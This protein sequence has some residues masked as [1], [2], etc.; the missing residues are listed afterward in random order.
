MT[1]FT[2]TVTS[3]QNAQEWGRLEVVVRDGP[4]AGQRRI[5]RSRLVV[6]TSEKSDLQ[7]KDRTVS[8]RHLSLEPSPNGVRIVD[9][10][11]RNGSWLD[12]CRI[13]DAELAPG[14]EIRIGATVLGLEV[15]D[16]STPDETDTPSEL[17]VSFGRF[18]GASSSLQLLYRQLHKAAATNATILL[19]GESGAGKE[20]LAE[21]VHEV[22]PRR[23]GPFIVLD[24]SSLPEKLIE[25]A[26]FGHEKGAF[27][28]AAQRRRGAF[29]EADKGT[30][31]LDEVGE[32]PLD[33]QTRLLRTLDRRQ[34]QRVGSSTVIPVDVRVVAATN[35]NLELEVEEGRFRL[36]VFHRL[37]VVMLRVPPL[38]ERRADIEPL[39]KHFV[40]SFGGDPALLT[41]T[42]LERL[43]THAWPGNVRELRNFVERLSVLGD[44]VGQFS[45]RASP[46]GE[47]DLEVIA[48]SGQAY[49]PAKAAVLETFNQMYVEA[50]LEAHG[51]N[52]SQAAEA[53]G[54]AR[55]HFQ[56]L[57]KG[58][59][60]G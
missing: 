19:E 23:E 49:R 27:T 13:I 1:E 16:G 31:F 54:V 6:G 42:V 47:G 14:D 29:E 38:R 48:R 21:A 60:D 2:S 52:V 30:I 20:L 25:S 59:D 17:H 50:M 34:V 51:G 58:S 18:R 32:L 44:D 46:S 55:R 24:C 53:A 37:A 35:R 5:V 57:K 33:L 7:L 22:S 45:T 3:P 8:R 26:L 39:A 56:R 4:D 12:T 36:D 9:L 41:P 28:G 15:G 40:E 10:G 43:M 11:S